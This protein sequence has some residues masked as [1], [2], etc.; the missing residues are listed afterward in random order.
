[1]PHRLPPSDRARLAGLNP[2]RGGIAFDL[3]RDPLPVNWMV[4]G[5]SNM[6]S[7]PKAIICKGWPLGS[8]LISNRQGLDR[9]KGN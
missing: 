1:M 7:T 2:I 6:H 5:Y 8:H 3:E 9:D 4:D